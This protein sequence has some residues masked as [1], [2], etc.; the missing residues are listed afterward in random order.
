MSDGRQTERTDL[1]WTRTALGFLVNGALV[2]RFA[3]D[4]PLGPVVYV[5]AGAMTLFGAALLVEARRLYASRADALD[6]GG[7]VARPRELRAVW[8]AT[9]TATLAGV[10][11]AV[12]SLFA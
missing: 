6:S 12:L 8:A 5:I 4:L 2:A 10:V 1:A 7:R 3:R 11:V 9:L